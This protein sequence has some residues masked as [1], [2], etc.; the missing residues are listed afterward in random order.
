MD[1]NEE[2][3]LKD[4]V[5]KLKRNVYGENSIYPGLLNEFAEVK[6]DVRGMKGTVEE[7]ASDKTKQDRL[8]RWGG[9]I[10]TAVVTALLIAILSQLA[11]LS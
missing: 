5:E 11:G 7:M 1:A 2:R 4:D 6:R 8:W 10:A 9:G 3:R